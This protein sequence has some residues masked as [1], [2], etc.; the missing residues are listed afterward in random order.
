LAACVL[1]EKDARLFQDISVF[2]VFSVVI[3]ATP[4]R[5]RNETNPCS[6]ALMDPEPVGGGGGTGSKGSAGSRDRW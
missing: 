5:K 6:I 1:Q 2:S 3:H 4:G